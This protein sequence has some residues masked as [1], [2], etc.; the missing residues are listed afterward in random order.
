MCGKYPP[1]PS[2][3]HLEEIRLLSEAQHVDTDVMMFAYTMLETVIAP[4]SSSV[5]NTQP[6]SYL[7]GEGRGKSL[8]LHNSLL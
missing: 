6:K 5:P 3:R 4:V 1:K 2:S 7:L 8:K